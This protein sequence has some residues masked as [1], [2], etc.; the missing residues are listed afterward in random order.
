MQKILDTLLIG[1]SQGSIYALMSLALVLVWRSTR[2]V[3]FAQAGQAVLSTYVGFEI[4]SRTGNFW[5]SLI[6]AVIAGALIGAAVDV[7]LMRVLFKHATSGPALVVAPV[8][9]TL[10][11]LGLIRS[12]VGLVWGGEYRSIP[13]PASKDGFT[14]GTTTIPFS[15]LNSVIVAAVALVLIAIS[16]LFTRTNLGLALRASAYAPEIARLAG[17]RTSQ[18]R[19][20]GWAIAGGVGGVA[21]MLI[22]S[23]NFLSPYSLDLLLVF[24]FIAAVVG[25]LES[26]VGAVVGAMI[27]GIGLTFILNYVN[28]SLT[29]VSGFVVLIIVLLVKP[30]GLIGSRKGRRA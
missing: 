4:A 13:A 21:G 27:L 5:I 11:L 12:I 2:V 3:N 26:M 24:G 23:Y 1:I 10:G 9:A 20:I 8:I 25:G 15:P 18:T 17:V 29:F 22:T 6:F 30:D 14:F 16:I 28:T 7:L 19:T